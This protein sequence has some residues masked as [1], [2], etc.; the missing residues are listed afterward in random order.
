MTLSN[1]MGDSNQEFYASYEGGV[2]GRDAANLESIYHVDLD[3]IVTETKGRSKDNSGIDN[4][5]DVGDQDYMDMT[6]KNKEPI[7]KDIRF[8]G[9]KKF[10]E[11][12]KEE[13]GRHSKAHEIHII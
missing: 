6:N 12:V 5:Y 7:P 13:L 4:E 3:E 11:K 9:A 1:G 8:Y 2:T 10:S